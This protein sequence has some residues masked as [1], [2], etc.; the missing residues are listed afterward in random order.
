MAVPLNKSREKSVRD[1]GLEILRGVAHAQERL[2]HPTGLNKPQALKKRPSNRQ[3]ISEIV[4]RL[5]GENGATGTISF[6]DGGDRQE[7]IIQLVKLKE[8]SQFESINL[9]L[10]FQS[11]CGAL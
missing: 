9:E 11:V 8:N 10:D 7:E 2:N 5:R 4:G 6:D 3:D 1:S